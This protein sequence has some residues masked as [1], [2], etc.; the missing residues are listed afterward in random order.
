[1]N[2]EKMIA[3][4]REQLNAPLIEGVVVKWIFTDLYG[5]NRTR[6]RHVY[7]LMRTTYKKYCERNDI[8]PIGK[9]VPHNV[10]FSYLNSMAIDEQSIL[11]KIENV[12]E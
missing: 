4:I 7:E 9:A 10:A 12:S 2:K 11:G 5:M 6:A 8:E 1:M 3:K